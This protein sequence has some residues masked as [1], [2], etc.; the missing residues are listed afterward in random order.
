MLITVRA[1]RVKF[2][3]TD[4]SHIWSQ[5]TLASHMSS[6]SFTASQNKKQ[7]LKEKINNKS[8]ALVYESVKRKQLQET[9]IFYMLLRLDCKCLK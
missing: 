8:C 5:L 7:K 9:Y 3:I 4:T 6:Q 2:V 1:L